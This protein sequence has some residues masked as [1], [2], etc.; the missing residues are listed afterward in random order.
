MIDKPH[1]L[2]AGLWPVPAAPASAAFRFAAL[3][4]AGALVL[5]VS[6]KAQAPFYP[7]PLTLQTLVVLVLGSVFGARLGVAA[8]ALYLLEGALGAPVF[9]G[10]PEK[11][12]GLA[13]MMGPTGGFLLGFLPAVGF[14]GACADR[15][16]DR[17]ALRL[18]AAM[19]LGHALIFAAGFA[20][21]AALIGAQKAFALGVAPFFVA[22]VVKTL[23][24]AGLVAGFWRLAPRSGQ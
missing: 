16:L 1:A 8:V 11:G 2:A 23:L 14:V 10:T 22:T 4:A 13:Y 24:A 20:W 19:S 15:G 5:T 6:A 18:I 21:L 12:L 17:T 3:A 7:V 9:A